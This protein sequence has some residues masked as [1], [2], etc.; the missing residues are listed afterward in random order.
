M[1]GIEYRISNRPHRYSAS[2][3]KGWTIVL[4]SK[5][6]S[7]EIRDNYKRLEEGWEE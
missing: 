1:E 2:N 4:L 5:A 3:V 6:I 7:I